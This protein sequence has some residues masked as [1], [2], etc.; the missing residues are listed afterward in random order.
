MIRFSRPIQDLL[1]QVQAALPVGI[2]AYLVGG[3]VRDALIERT[4]QDLDFV[5]AGD[6]LG[7]ARRVAKALGAAYFPLDE[8]RNTARLVLSQ[9]DGSRIKLDF[10]A[11]RGPDLES[12]L[13][14]RDFTINA[15]AS[16]LA[17][18]DNLVDPTGGAGDLINRVLRACSP[19]SFLDDPVRVLRAIRLATALNC[20]ILSE[21]SHQLRQ[22]VPLL[23]QV[24]PER[25]RDELF[26]IM[27]GPQPATGVRLLD[28]LGA[29]SY[30]LPEILSLK[31]VT[32][33]PP[34]ISKVWEHTLEV[35]QRLDQVLDVLAVQY[36]Q[37][38]AASWALGFI[39]VQLGRFRLPL[40]E[41]LRTPINPERTLRGILFLAAL[42]HDAGKP[43][44][45]RVDEGGRIR[46]FEHEQVSAELATHRG[47]ALRLSNLE[48]ER[49]AVIV[50][51]HM[52]PHLLTQTGAPP[53]RRAIYRYFKACGAAGI[54]VG[55]LSLADS[56]ATYGPTLPQEIWSRHLLV[57]RTLFEAWWERP[58]QA[59]SPPALLD[60]HDL[61]RNFDLNPGPL[62][63]Q[64]LEM[65][66]EA[67]A[68]GQINSR[69]Q[70][71]AL[72]AKQLAA[73][74]GNQND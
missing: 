23:A 32:Q 41:H 1:R 34:H 6:V 9:S 13:R 57:I 63:G 19:H 35:V 21:T 36:E 39:S 15:I 73:N 25:L 68:A 22:A 3:A 67:Q 71:F 8:E 65:I 48:I 46:F 38:K 20:K 12:D 37:E 10:A 58:S 7:L 44:T 59:I 66:R 2:Q 56:L 50:R 55:L 51:N 45:H 42:Y 11:M 5:L 17:A 49:L 72:A 4:T 33:P 31:G 69:E 28:L 61:M 70:A 62:V 16:P 43:G 26:R 14:G 30:A 27:E 24:S 54:D 74:Q 29:L 60:G 53:T 47:R 64:L 18:P 52:R 40:D